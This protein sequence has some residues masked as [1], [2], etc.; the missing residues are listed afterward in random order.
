MPKHMA[1]IQW[2]HFSHFSHYGKLPSTAYGNRIN[3]AYKPLL[4]ICLCL[5]YV[6][7]AHEGAFNHGYQ[8]NDHQTAY[9]VKFNTHH[10]YS[11]IKRKLS[12]GDQHRA[13]RFPVITTPLCISPL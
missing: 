6:R 8:I 2:H 3:T 5:F 1:K 4:F 13:L 9:V 12:D 11:I 7:I 10:M